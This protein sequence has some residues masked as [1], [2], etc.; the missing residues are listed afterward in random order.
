MRKWI[1]SLVVVSLLIQPVYAQDVNK[2][3]KLLEEALAALAVPVPPTEVV[4]ITTPEALDAAL[5]VASPGS[6]ISLGPELVYPKLLTLKT[7][8][9]ILGSKVIEG[10]MTETEALPLFKDGM[11]IT[12]SDIVV[13]GVEVKKIDPL[14]DIVVIRGARITFD[15]NRVLGDRDKGAKRGIAAN[16]GGGIVITRNYID[17]CFQSYPGND[18]QAIIAWDMAPGL[19][20]EDNYLSA[21]SEVIMLGGSDS[22][23][24]ERMPSEIQIRKNTLTRRPEWQFKL[25]GVKN[26]FEIKA[27]R[28][29]V[30]EDNDLSNVWGGHGQDGY[31]FAFTVRNQ[32]GKAPWST[33]EGVLV[34]NNRVS[35]A[36]AFATFLGMDNNHPSGTM[37]RV[38]LKDNIAT[39]ID[40]VKYTGA[41][42]LIQI[43]GRSQLV[44]IVGQNIKGTG[45]SSNVYF[46]GPAASHTGMVLA[47]S[48]FPIA[49]YGIVFGEGAAV[50]K[51]GQIPPAWTRYV[52]DGIY[53]NNVMQAQ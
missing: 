13:R 36:A 31:A 34:Q 6:V 4:P 17:D 43:G 42:K 38:I 25:I 1:S 41:N 47:D 8:V 14:V 12:G 50:G 3:R 52:V 11:L 51:P 18:S 46:Y 16:G 30:F 27:G 44:S 10:R 9:T 5:A 26:L 7:S 19:L 33:I 28:N 15:R 24:A 22:S 49:K 29:I 2:A 37:L 23:S 20:I 45:I 35:K 48:I 21:G 53:S 32:D 39:E 40:P